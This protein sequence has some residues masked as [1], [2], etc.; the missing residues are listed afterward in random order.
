SAAA[1]AAPY[2]PA[3]LFLNASA[4]AAELSLLPPPHHLPSP[5]EPLIDVAAGGWSPRKAASRSAEPVAKCSPVAFITDWPSR[6]RASAA[7]SSPA[8]SSIVARELRAN[9]SS[10]VAP[11]VRA[12]V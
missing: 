2:A 10:A 8:N 7:L 12:C 1:D 6:I 4:A 5:A 11:A 3:P 9:C